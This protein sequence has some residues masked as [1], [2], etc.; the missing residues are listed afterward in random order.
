MYISLLRPILFRLEAETAH[1]LTISALKTFSYTPWLLRLLFGK[2]VSSTSR[3]LFGLHFQNPIG[4][5]A[6]MDKNAV[7]LPAWE[8]LGFGFV[9]V[10]TITALAQP[11]NPQPRLFRYP[12]SQALINRMGFNNDGCEAVATRLARL[13]QSGRWP[14]IPV[15]INIGKSKVTPLEKAP[16]DYLESYQRLYPFGD[17]FVINVSSPNTP[18]LRKL[19]DAEQLAAILDTLRDWEGSRHK[20]LLVKLAPDLEL[21]QLKDAITIAES[22]GADGFIATNTTLNHHPIP[23]NQDQ[24]GGLS[25]SPLCTQAKTILKQ[26]RSMTSL[27]IIASGGIMTPKDAIERL[28]AGA[29]LIQLYTGFVYHGP[30]LIRQIA[31]AVWNTSSLNRSV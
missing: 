13:K 19:Q 31:K 4:L 18:G 2:N 1:H 30:A 22:R 21:T 23:A 12:N 9:E 16:T 8:A 29:N 5:A 14:N 26:A 25:G 15:G 3:E 6:G 10:G 17:Y 11:G 27:P 24:Q 20:P 28:E 7:A